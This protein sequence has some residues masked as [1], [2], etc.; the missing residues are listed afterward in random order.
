MCQYAIIGDFGKRKG[1]L[2]Y[3][4]GADLSRANFTLWR[5]LTCPTA[6]D[7]KEMAGGEMFRILPLQEGH[8]YEEMVEGR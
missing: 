6:M 1:R 5:M 7:K 8:P 4:A 2:V 3:L